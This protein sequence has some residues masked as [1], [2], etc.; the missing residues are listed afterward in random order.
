MF[1]A[2]WTWS[3]PSPAVGQDH[4]SAA[5]GVLSHDEA[6]EFRRSLAGHASASIGEFCGFAFGLLDCRVEVQVAQTDGQSAKCG[7]QRVAIT[8]RMTGV[9]AAQQGDSFSAGGNSLPV[10]AQV[11]EDDAVGLQA[12]GEGGREGVGVRVGQRPVETGGLFDRDQRLLGAAQVGQSLRQV[13]Q[14]NGEVGDEGV[15][16]GRGQR[17]VGG[18]GLLV[19][20]QRL[21]AAAEVA[22]PDGQVLQRA[23]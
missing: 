1:A 22:Q 12:D 19:D 18:G 11:G 20:R 2:S 17:P 7:R 10:P 9:Q 5:R 15:G 23:G 6:P 3:E 14:R 16:V 13:V 21:L 4:G 8:V